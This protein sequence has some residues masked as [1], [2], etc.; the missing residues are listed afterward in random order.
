MLWL[1][2]CSQPAKGVGSG[3]RVE[4]PSST[5]ADVAA[6]KAGNLVTADE[7]SAEAAA[8][9]Q[10]VLAEQD[11]QRAASAS[12]RDLRDTLNEHVLSIFVAA[13]ADMK[14]AGVRFDR[15]EYALNTLNVARRRQ[16]VFEFNTKRTD[17]TDTVRIVGDDLTGDPF[18]IVYLSGTNYPQSFGPDVP[19]P[20]SDGAGTYLPGC[21]V[22][23]VSEEFPCR[24]VASGRLDSRI[25]ALAKHTLTQA[26]R[27]STR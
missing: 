20:V 25:A 21:R 16:G 10:R 24:E 13:V 6:G 5:P 23:I 4:S 17:P 18:A 14:R 3:D 7:L 1:G 15:A 9:Q 19:R 27:D 22:R 8:A 11:H 2:A 12:E 26:L